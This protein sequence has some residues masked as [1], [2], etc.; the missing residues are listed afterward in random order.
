M[1]HVLGIP[2]RSHHTQLLEALDICSIKQIVNNRTTGLFHR[3]CQL[4][5]SPAK[6]ICMFELTEYILYNKTY[7]GTIVHRLTQQGISP[8]HALSSKPEKCSTSSSQDGTVDSLRQLIMHE[9]FIKPWSSQ[10]ILST[11][12]TKAF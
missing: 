2:K 5:S 4:Q 12:L 3:I 7:S 1:K 6:D 8:L 11:L 10:H 9:Q